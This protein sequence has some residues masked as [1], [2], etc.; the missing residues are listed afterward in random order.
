[1]NDELD[2]TKLAA[3]VAGDRIE[4][5][6]H[7]LRKKRAIIGKSAE[8]MMPY[9]ITAAIECG[10]YGDRSGA[11][12]AHQSFNAAMTLWKLLREVE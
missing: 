11:H 6:D 3:E 1:M 8:A 9:A 2:I 7:A 4:A 12:A 5:D 10:R